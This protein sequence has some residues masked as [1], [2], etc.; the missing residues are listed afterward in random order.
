[1]REPAVEIL[2]VQHDQCHVDL[3]LALLRRYHLAN[4]IHVVRDATEALEFLFRSGAYADRRP[5][6]PRL[7]LYGI[8][9]STHREIECLER[10]KRNGRT[11]HIPITVVAFSSEHRA[12]ALNLL[13]RHG[14]DLP[15]VLIEDPAARK[16]GREVEGT[17]RDAPMCD[18]N[19]ALGK[20]AVG[21]ERAWPREVRREDT[22]EVVDLADLCY[23]REMESLARLARGIAH[24]FNTMFAAIVA[25]TE[26][27]TQDLA[28]D[29]PRRLAA[30]SVFKSIAHASKLT[31][32]MM[33]LAT[34][35]RRRSAQASSEAGR[36]RGK[37]T[38]KAM[39]RPV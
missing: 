18:E 13:R 33:A 24:E 14:V 2:L 39:I 1:M 11:A 3:T 26:L 32:E 19:D 21:G 10:I 31:R 9:L 36:G 28:P 7:V 20:G 25:Y 16:T 34:D 15:V 37:R 35:T 5:E 38:G 23:D 4:R 17:D 6:D 27:L 30:D 29:D 22:G 12:A 8:P